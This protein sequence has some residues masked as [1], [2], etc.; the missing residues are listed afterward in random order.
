MIYLLLLFNNLH[1]VKRI[2][3]KT[4]HQVVNGRPRRTSHVDERLGTI[5]G[6]FLEIDQS[7]KVVPELELIILNGCDHIILFHSSC[8]L[9]VCD[10]SL[11]PL[12]YGS[13][14]PCI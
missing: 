6:I 1:L 12:P 8:L 4:D 14:I 10:L 7:L 13:I 11:F 3:A 5:G 9:L 2:D